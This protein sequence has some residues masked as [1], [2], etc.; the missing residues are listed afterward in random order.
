MPAF[1]ELLERNIQVLHEGSGTGACKQK[2]ISVPVTEAEW[3]KGQ[4]RSLV[5]GMGQHVIDRPQVLMGWDVS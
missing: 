3:Q 1:K 5:V 4:L 2:C